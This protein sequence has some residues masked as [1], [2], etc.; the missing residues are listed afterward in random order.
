MPLCRG[1]LHV[2]WL[3]P[4]LGGLAAAQ[5]KAPGPLLEHWLPGSGLYPIEVSINA[6]EMSGEPSEPAEPEEDLSPEQALERINDRLDEAEKRGML[7]MQRAQV[8]LRLGNTD[9]SALDLMEAQAALRAEIPTE[10]GNARLVLGLAM[11]ST[12]LGEVD[13]A[14]SVLREA[15]ESDPA[16]AAYVAHLMPLLDEYD[17]TIVQRSLEAVR[18]KLQADPGDSKALSDLFM[19]SMV[20]LADQDLHSDLMDLAG[21]G[22][23]QGIADRLGLMDAFRAHRDAH[24]DDPVARWWLGKAYVVMGQMGTRSLMATAKHGSPEGPA[25]R[26]MAPAGELLADAPGHPRAA[27]S[28]YNALIVYHALRGEGQEVIGV[29]E[30]ARQAFPDNES[31]P[32]LHAELVAEVG[33]DPEA[34]VRIAT[35]ALEDTKTFAG[36]G[37][38]AWVSA[39]SGDYPR[40]RQ[41]SGALLTEPDAVPGTVARRAMLVTAY[42]QAAQ[43][44]YAGAEE[45]VNQVLGLAPGLGPAI[46]K[47]IILA[48]LGETSA[49]E[50]MLID[51]ATSNPADTASRALIGALNP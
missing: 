34:G 20:R 6:E 45:L 4:L 2:I 44:D 39:L 13:K 23:Y 3:L 9:E 47:A 25:A 14:I 28:T 24:P 22:D 26:F 48:L 16:E 42:T 30:S 41:L 46:D 43:G 15:L 51:I 40:A 29:V 7:L 11:V 27:A 19:L 5:Q 10:P 36:V 12:Q 32:F 21:Q 1:T 18:A 8:H 37:S 31:L 17:D 33:G 50:D 49:A 38:L 35:E